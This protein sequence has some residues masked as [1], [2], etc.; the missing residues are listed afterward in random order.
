MIPACRSL[1]SEMP[2]FSPPSDYLRMRMVANFDELLTTRINDEINALCWRRE[3]TADFKGV[4]EKRN[5]KGGI[6]PLNEDFPEREFWNPEFL[7]AVDDL[8]KPI[9]V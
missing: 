9:R 3:L 2:V 4:I 5:L 8:G 6:N 1:D 7:A